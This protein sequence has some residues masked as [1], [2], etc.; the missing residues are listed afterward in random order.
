ME[1]VVKDKKMKSEP[2]V[3]IFGHSLD[4][5]EKIGKSRTKTYL[6]AENFTWG[7]LFIFAGIIFLLNTFGILPW[8]VWGTISHFW[9]VFLILVGVDMIFGKSLV[10]KIIGLNF[11]VLTF[12]VVLGVALTAVAP[13][14]I[15]WLPIE[16][17]NFFNNIVLYLQVK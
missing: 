7:F 11:K 15:S 8:N 13:Q 14:T 1:N 10:A 9:P 5:E 16:I 12:L 2:S 6:D 4:D 17:T 3:T